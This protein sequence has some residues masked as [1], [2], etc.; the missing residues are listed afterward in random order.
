MTKSLLDLTIE[1]EFLVSDETYIFPHYACIILRATD[2]DCKSYNRKRSESS[3][4]VVL[5]HNFELSLR[6]RL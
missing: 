3:E 4:I 1:M 2:V 6:L 5:N